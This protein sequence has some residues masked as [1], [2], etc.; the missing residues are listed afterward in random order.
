MKTRENSKMYALDWAVKKELTI[1][2]INKDKLSSVDSSIPEFEKFLNKIKEPSSFYL[3]E[4]GGDSFKLLAI[5]EGHQVFTIPGIKVKEERDS[6]NIPKSDGGDAKTIGLLAKTSSE[7]FYKFQESDKLVL[8]ICIFFKLRKDAEE[9]LVRQKNRF[10]AYN[11]T[12]ELLNLNGFYEK[13][14]KEKEE[15]IRSLQ[16]EFDLYSKLLKKEVLK[17][18]LWD[19]FFKDIKG[20]GEAVAGG[21]IARV[22]RA[23]RFKNRGNLRHYAGMI[24][25]K[26][27][28][29]FDHALKRALYFFSD[30][31]I[32]HRDPKWRELYDNMKVFYR[33]KHPEPIVVKGKKH[34]NDG[35]I[36]NLAR[37][38]VQTK[39]L[40]KVYEEM[41]KLENGE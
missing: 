14:K 25:K 15:T 34:Y 3:E 24:E 21:I 10:F 12:S 4:G 13:I 6:L 20:V 16:K 41:I 39:F 7:I 35:H 28:Q 1:Y 9:T 23:S 26:G 36:D 29:K 11:K 38:F 17:Y 40:D 32:K 30:G 37:K 22:K 2:N 5:R 33:E 31:I 18:P 27:N 8:R 19:S